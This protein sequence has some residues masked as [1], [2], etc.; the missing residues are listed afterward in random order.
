MRP[1][2]PTAV[3]LYSAEGPFKR[4][5]EEILVFQSRLWAERKKGRKQ[6]TVNKDRK[7]VFINGLDLNKQEKKVFVD[8]LALVKFR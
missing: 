7:N 1:S 6:E 4:A 5:D 3:A 2:G 8:R